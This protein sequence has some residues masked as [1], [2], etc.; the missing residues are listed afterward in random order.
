VQGPG[1]AES[2]SEG[3]DYTNTPDSLPAPT[4]LPSAA[5]AWWT[6]QNWLGE[7]V[8]GRNKQADDCPLPG[9]DKGQACMPLGLHE[10]LT[11]QV[12]PD[13]CLHGVGVPA[14]LD[15]QLLEVKAQY[16]FSFVLIHA[17]I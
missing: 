3:W 13:P 8:T 5:P 17:H 1:L 15:C 7:A 10:V 11:L 16:L 4:Q 9:E 12:H 14:L 2:P 6:G